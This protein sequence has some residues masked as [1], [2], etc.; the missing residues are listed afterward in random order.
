MDFKVMIN[1]II[2]YSSKD[3]IYVI[4]HIKNLKYL[5]MFLIENRSLIYDQ[6]FM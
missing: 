4:S 1:Y 3:A 2:N 6:N 5:K